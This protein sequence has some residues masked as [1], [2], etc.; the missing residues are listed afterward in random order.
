MEI[1]KKLAYQFIAIF[2]LILL[3]S[4]LTIY[5]SFSNTRKADF[6][7]RLEGKVRQVAQIL[8]EAE[9]LDSDLL[10]KIESSNPVNLPNE[11]I[12]IYDMR[13]QLLYSTDYNA[14]LN[15]SGEEINR[16]R[17][18]GKVQLAQNP[19]EILGQYFENDRGQFVIFAGATDIFG[20]QKLK[21]LRLIQLIVFF[22]SL[23]I[24]YF[25]G[26]I[27]ATRAL[28]PISNIRSQ[29]EAIGVS[30]LNARVDEG[31]GNDEI[32]RLARTF[33]RML[34]RL[35]LAFITQKNF[36]ANASHEL[37]TPLT[38][39]TG[40]LEVILMKDRSKEEYRETIL[41]L[42]EDIQ[43]MN[44]ISNR[45]LLLAQTSSEFP[46]TG[47]EKVR[48]DDTIWQARN[49]VLKRQHQYKVNVHFSEQI[50]NE[51]KLTINGHEL[52]LKTALLNL[53]DN[54]CK[55]SEDHRVDIN[56]DSREE[57]II[58]RFSDKG[59]GIPEEELA[60]V[61]QPFYRAS[62]AK[63][64]KGHG[65]GLSLAEKIITLHGGVI[66]VSSVFKQGTDISIRFHSVN[67]D[68]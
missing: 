46:E 31:T 13:D 45:L 57:E 19:F 67:P 32:T 33:N 9:S 20:L 11:K 10:K 50:D 34:D 4:S 26:R 14:Q 36:I 6:Y 54:G 56:L 28:F 29:A 38:V 62:N 39:M 59:I 44:Q 47:F 58:I 23:I 49:E 17:V 15:I 53:M 8:T 43:N 7:D 1:R 27:F 60:S 3:L 51:D 18:H 25:A 41:S 65:I 24:V 35:E 21:H 40:Q 55:Y 48:I 64:I 66:Q 63:S 22:L 5:L 68:L 16:V 37:R 12:V 52:L 30:N 2:A 61:F 42:L